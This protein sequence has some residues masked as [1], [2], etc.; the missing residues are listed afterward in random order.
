MS[1]MSAKCQK[2]LKKNHRFHRQLSL[3][4]PSSEW[5]A[6]QLSFIKIH[7]DFLHLIPSADKFVK[8]HILFYQIMQ[9]CKSIR[10]YS[11]M[12]ATDGL[13]LPDK[14]KCSVLSTQ[15]TAQV[16]ELCISPVFTRQDGF[17]VTKG[18][19]SVFLQDMSPVC[20]K[21]SR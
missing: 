14:Y 18:N 7:K 5:M 1:E 3:V 15:R 17:C 8:L 10:D 11:N 9:T 20:D 12:L 16:N 4:L 2:W 19:E 6:P 13:L 21:F